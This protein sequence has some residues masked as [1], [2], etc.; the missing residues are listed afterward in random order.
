MPQHIGYYDLAG[1]PFEAFTISISGGE[2]SAVY[3]LEIWNDKLD[4]YLDTTTA[5]NAWLKILTSVVIDYVDDE[6]IYGPYESSGQPMLDDRW[7]TARITH[8]LDAD[9]ATTEGATGTQAI[10]ANADLALPDLAPQTGV[11][12][13]LQLRAPAGQTADATKV[14]LR[15]V[16]GEGSSPLAKFSTL[17]TGSGVV[18][19][20]RIEGLRSI[21]TGSVVTADDTDTITVSGGT[22]AYDGVTAAFPAETVT[23]DLEDADAVELDAGE[24]YLVTLSRAAD[25]DLTVTKSAK[26]ATEYPDVPDDE[27][28]VERLTVESADGVAVTVAPSSLQGGMRHAAFAVHAGTG[29]TVIVS[30]GDGVTSTDHRQHQ[31]HEIVVAVAAS[32]TNRIWRVFSG[33]ITATTTD[34]PPSIGAD[35]LAYVTTDAGAVTA[36]IDARQFT[37]RAV[38]Y[39]FL[40]LRYVGALSQLVTPVELLAWDVLDDDGELE[41]VTPD[42]SALDGTWTSGTLRFDIRAIPPGVAVDDAGASIYTDDSQRPS[43]EW[44]ADTLHG[45]NAGHQTRR[46]VK[47]TR[48]VL[49]ALST[50][51]APSAE[52]AQEVRLRL[53][54]RRYR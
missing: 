54:F 48:F 17:A 45:E 18:P 26:A 52:P 30:A 25:G 9:G 8:T 40:D 53:R 24:H 29:L 15:V 20:D 43:F 13:E 32:S 10:G 37:H 11:R 51:A 19:P 14:K 46:F 22:L 50:F 27:I 34:T 35:L 7:F 31:S 41:A 33:G 47:G 44:D 39:W 36:I 21:L 42:L 3:T 2:D 38:V 4:A 5:E 6:P 1:D 12:V 49:D 16:G 23:F 28:Y